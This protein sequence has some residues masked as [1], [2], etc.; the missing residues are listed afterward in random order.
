M[1]RTLP[2]LRPGGILADCLKNEQIGG[3]F[4]ALSEAGNSS[5]VCGLL[6]NLPKGVK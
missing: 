6:R 2:S 5:R 1:T 4:L 3:S